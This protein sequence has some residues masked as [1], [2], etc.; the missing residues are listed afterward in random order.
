MC[1]EPQLRPRF[2]KEELEAAAAGYDVSLDRKVGVATCGGVRKGRVPT[3]G[4]IPNRRR[5]PYQPP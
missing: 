2:T 5:G 3:G 1:C 4:G